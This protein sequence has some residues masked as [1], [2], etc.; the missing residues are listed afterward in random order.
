MEIVSG[1]TG[2]VTIVVENLDTAQSFRSSDVEV[3]ATPRV[4][5]LMEEATCKA[6]DGRLPKHQTTVGVR[7]Q[8]DHLAPTLP[9]MSVSAEAQL[10][11]VEGKRL[12]F[13]VKTFD[14]K[15]LLAVG[16]IIR[17]IVDRD[18]FMAR[19]ADH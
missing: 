12:Q 1:L 14:S 9:G 15:G 5:A 16:V 2:R 7:V 19:A 10:T 3:L 17:V 13:K 18:A 4:V 6:I 11:K 8:V